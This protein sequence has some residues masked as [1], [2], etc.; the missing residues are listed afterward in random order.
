MLKKRLLGVVTVRNGWAVQS[1]GYH[2]YLPL[3]RVETIVDNLDRWGVDEI[4][5]QC[6][7]RTAHGMGPNL[8]VL[9]EVARV[10]ISTPL[11]YG[12]GIAN[13]EQAV[14]VVQQ[15]ADRIVIDRL[16]HDHPLE[17]E[18]I[19]QRLGSQA[20]VAALPAIGGGRG[21]TP[22]NY[23][24]RTEQ[25]WSAESR[26]LLSQ[27]VISEVMLI[28]VQHEG[29]PLAFDETL[30]D[31][32]LLEGI[33]LIVFGGISSETQMRQL[34][35]RGNVSAVAVGN[36]LNYREHAAQAYKRGLDTMWMRP[37]RYDGRLAGE[38]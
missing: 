23:R 4:L 5:I 2:R 28:D 21:A 20:V 35:T 1:F 36:F 8:D 12:G 24:Q 27:G 33:Q 30:L 13:S 37:A 25:L 17:V 18:A 11:V 19:A 3:G 26:A 15:G 31:M 22:W 32:P 9:R 7:D 16:I 38:Q 6:I 29:Q 34:L 14:S 10:G